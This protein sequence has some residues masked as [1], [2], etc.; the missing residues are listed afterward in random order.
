MREV[1]LVTE[2]TTVVGIKPS[3][4]RQVLLL[5]MTQMP[6]AYQVSRVVVSLFQVLREY[7]LLQWQAI[8]RFPSQYPL[9]HS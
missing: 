8:W 9:M 4:S 1:V 5:V 2:P 7:L 6:L 3:K